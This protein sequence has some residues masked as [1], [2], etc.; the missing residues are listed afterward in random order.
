M[1]SLRTNDCEWS[2][3]GAAGKRNVPGGEGEPFPCRIIGWQARI[4]MLWNG[5]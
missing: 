4:K 3:F 2:M 5:Q 1:R